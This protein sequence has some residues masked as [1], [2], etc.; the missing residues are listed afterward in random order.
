MAIY[1]TSFMNNATDIGSLVQGFGTAIEPT[2]NYLIGS[3]I[4]LSFFLIVLITSSKR[5]DT[6]QAMV[7]TL[8]LTTMLALPLFAGGFISSILL[9]SP[10]VGFV[11]S[12]VFYL[13]TK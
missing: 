13:F 11:I 4:L 7:L 8:F 1:N 10:F 6:S 3:L 12:I 2:G 5:A 9:I